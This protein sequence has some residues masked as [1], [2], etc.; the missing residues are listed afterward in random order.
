MT[1]C[2]CVGRGDVG[3]GFGRQ[4]GGAAWTLCRE[5][6]AGRRNVMRTPRTRDTRG[7]KRQLP[8]MRQ[9]RD[10]RRLLGSLNVLP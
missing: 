2:I 7:H 4:G 6:M 3:V 5:L 9:E 8:T 1:P 10:R